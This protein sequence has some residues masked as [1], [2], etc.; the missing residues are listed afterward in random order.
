[1][2]KDRV[3]RK[4]LKSATLLVIRM[5]SNGRFHDSM[6]C[7]HCT[8]TMQKFGIRKVAYSD[9]KGDIV[10][11]NIKDLVGSRPSS[12]YRILKRTHTTKDS[13]IRRWGIL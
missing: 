12:G 2:Y 6:P 11:K 10:E 9:K 5:N 3:V 4:R 8:T 1:M 7:L 13:H